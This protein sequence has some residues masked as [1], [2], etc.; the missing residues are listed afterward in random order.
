M[1]YSRLVPLLATVVLLSG[2]FGKL[3]FG[4]TRTDGGACEPIADGGP[5]APFVGAW[6]C[7]V[8]TTGT[9]KNPGA[10]V[11]PSTY[12]VPINFSANEGG[13][14]SMTVELPGTCPSVEF[15][16]S[17][18]TATLN[19]AQDCYEE[20]TQVDITYVSGTITVSMCG[21]TISNLIID[22][23]AIEGAPADQAVVNTENGT[24]TK[25]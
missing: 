22:V 3:L 1:I 11:E 10:T 5:T 15:S 8:T 16:V 19:G 7:T 12:T 14:L 20:T 2:C 24:C 17:D 18:G 9:T 6:T 23:P 4:D 25:N 13:T 21:A